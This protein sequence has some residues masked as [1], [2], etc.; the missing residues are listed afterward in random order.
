MFISPV[1]MGQVPRK[2]PRQSLETALRS[3]GYRTRRE[4]FELHG[5]RELR[6]QRRFH[7]KVETHGE[8][9]VPKAAWIDLHID[10]LNGDALG[11]HGY[12]VEGE[13]IQAE[14]ELIVETILATSAND[15][16]RTTC[17]ECGK[18]LF[19]DH[20]ENHLIIEHRRR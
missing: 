16:K 7:A 19:A 1:M 3:I 10:R 9:T 8:D 18:E 11:R 6:G 12:E 20:L 17:S 2:V 14:L 4:T 15:T 13:V 5:Y